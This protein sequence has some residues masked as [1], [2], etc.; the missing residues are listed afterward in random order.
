MP[1]TNAK[2]AE[3]FAKGPVLSF[4]FYPDGSLIIINIVGQKQSFNPNQVKHARALLNKPKPAP[5]PPVG[6]TG[7]SP[8]KARRKPKTSKRK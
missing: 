6:A 2:L 4:N 5:K 1:I 7:R 8:S 3:Y